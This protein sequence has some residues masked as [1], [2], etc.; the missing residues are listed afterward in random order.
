M[1]NDVT[2]G[3]RFVQSMALI[4]EMKAITGSYNKAS[5]MHG[6]HLNLSNL[7]P[8]LSARRQQRAARRWKENTSHGH[9]RT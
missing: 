4:D 8:M 3:T 9:A 5:K 7:V 6:K 1:G 2:T